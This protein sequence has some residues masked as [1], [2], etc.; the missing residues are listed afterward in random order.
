ML[1][2][3]RLHSLDNSRRTILS[4]R[5]NLCGSCS[6]RTDL[7]TNSLVFAREI[8]KSPLWTCASVGGTTFGNSCLFSS[9]RNRSQETALTLR[10]PQLS[11]DRGNVSV[12]GLHPATALMTSCPNRIHCQLV[13]NEN[14]GLSTS[15]ADSVG[16]GFILP[17]SSARILSVRSRLRAVDTASSLFL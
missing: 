13:G 2:N 4:L 15:I 17:A 11:P 16:S 1:T 10:T 3:R 6:T 9:A 12:L 14:G 7:A 8:K 5:I